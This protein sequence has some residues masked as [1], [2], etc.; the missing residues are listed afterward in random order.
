[1]ASLFS[2]RIIGINLLALTAVLVCLWLSNWQW[3]K[4]HFTSSSTTTGQVQDFTE[5]SPLRDYLPPTSV[6]VSTTITGT[7]QPNSRLLFGERPA[8]G[9]ALINPDPSSV[10][11][12]SWAVPVGSWVLD[13]VILPNGSSVGVVHGW[14][15]DGKVSPPVDGQVTLTG[16][17]QPS[18]ESLGNGLF[19]LPEYITTNN[20][21]KVSS[22]NL[23]DG[24][25][26]VD[27][28]TAG[29]E[30]VTPIFDS[31]QKVGLHWRNVVYTANWIVFAIIIA[32][33]WWR[34]I[35][36]ELKQPEKETT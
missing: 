20:I 4:A 31:P 13:A 7:W 6:G 10:A 1:M 25:F 2:K 11:I 30:K 26:V 8:D 29:L 27:T 28:P 15:E 21:L 5:L 14:L 23:H 22:T 34:I 35:Q 33:M 3:G 17:M 19:Q 24:Y 9:K 18:E 32:A 36:D 12:P 16:V